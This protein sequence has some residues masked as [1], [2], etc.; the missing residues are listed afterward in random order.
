MVYDCLIIG[1]GVVGCAILQEL[2]K[3]NLKSILLEKEDDVSCGASRANSGIVHAGYDCIPNSLMAKFNVEGCKIMPELCKKLDVPCKNVGS[4][5]VATKDGLDKI[6]A[7]YKRG[8]ANGVNVQILNRE[9]TIKIEP[10]IAEQIEYSLYAKEACIVSPYKLTIALADIS[11]LNGAEIKLENEVLS[12][13]KQGDIFCVTTNVG[14][15][16]AK[17]VVN[18]AGNYANDINNMIGAENFKMS[19]RRGDYF[20]LDSVEHD[21]IKT[22]IFQL[23]SERGKGVLVAPTVD[24][25][26][27]YGPT[28][29]ITEQDNNATTQEGFSEIVGSIKNSY[30]FCNLK[31]VIRTYAGVRAI[32]GEDF[33]VQFS[34]KIEN[35]FMLVGICSP[36]LS[37]APAIAKFVCQKLVDCLHAQAKTTILSQLQHTTLKKLTSEEI[38]KKIKEDKNWGK[39]V[40]RCETVTEAEIIN[41]IHSPLPATTVD[42]IKRRTRAGMGRCQGG[43]CA[44]KVME[45][46][47]R[48]LDIDI[49]KVKKGGK[50][51]YLIAGEIKSND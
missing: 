38:N 15:Y 26:V 37:S 48:E 49:K 29:V 13:K 1:G 34:N 7:L 24:G 4:I 14:E 22:V 28:S 27:F 33:I 41:A 20:L 25:N 10:N 51:S 5:V 19:F 32:S 9:Q 39:V 45:I 42:A 43:F 30:K 23:P 35:F 11:I 12:I 8:V 44:T 40:C 16:F 2:S 17:Y 6:D 3:Y 21:N 31:N 36:G 50:D 47:A 46:I 18:C